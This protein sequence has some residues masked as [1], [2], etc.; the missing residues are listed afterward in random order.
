MPQ[1]EWLPF[2]APQ[3][4]DII[5]ILVMSFV[6][7]KLLILIKGTRAVQML[8][9]IVFL[10]IIS[11]V[12]GLLGLIALKTTVDYTISFLPI[13][14]IVLFQNEIRKILARLGTNPVLSLS[15]QPEAD[16]EIDQI[17]R[18][19]E[20]LSNERKGALIIIQQ[21]EGL[22]HQAET[23]ITLD[24][25]ISYDLLVSIFEPNTPLH[26]GAVLIVDNRVA[27]AGCLLPLSSNPSLP[28][29]F[30]TRHR[31]GVGIT[32]ETD[33]VA[34]IVSEETGR[35]SFAKNG[36]MMHYKDRST[37]GLKRHFEGLLTMDRKR[38]PRSRIS[39]WIHTLSERFRRSNDTE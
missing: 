3:L 19:A 26:D 30:G 32:E 18:A 13:A 20:I 38:A 15:T 8:I 34:V 12:S 5:D 4:I 37:E 14:I 31:A 21:E 1:L 35:I 7:Y 36:M 11:Y 27:A 39:G 25:R 29:H 22:G 28:P 16:T 10:M 2:R 17:V 24:A 23:G 9:G 6:V 33:A